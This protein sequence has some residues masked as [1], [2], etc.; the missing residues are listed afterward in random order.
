LPASV[1]PHERV[2]VTPFRLEGSHVVRHLRFKSENQMPMTEKQILLAVRRPLK[3]FRT[4]NLATH[5]LGA[6]S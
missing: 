2:I 5:F 1:K 3:R 4:V 6:D